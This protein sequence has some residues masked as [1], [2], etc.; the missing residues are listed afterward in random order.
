MVTD[1]KLYDILGVVPNATEGDI[2]KAYTKLSKIWHPDKHVTSTDAEKEEAHCK[3]QEINNAKEILLDSE[4]RCLYDQIGMDIMNNNGS[5]PEPDMHNPF[6]HMFRSHF[7]FNGR[8]QERNSGP[9]DIVE[10]LKVTLD[11]IYNEETMPFSYMQKHDCSTCN[12]E[13]TK[14]GKSS[15]CAGCNGKGMRVRIIRNGNMIQ[16][17]VSNCNICNSTGRV[18]NNENKC[19]TCCGNKFTMKEKTIQIP[20]KS[21]LTNGHKISLDGKGN[22]MKNIKSNLI[23]N[24][25][26]SPHQI[27][28]RKNNDLFV[29]MELKLYQVLFGFDK[30]FS[31]KSV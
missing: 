13:G 24:I 6:E 7:N 2:K 4:K 9:E 25:C 31:G 23:I 26:E 17:A 20:L 21:H 22:H 27:F 15:M 8:Q 1:T 11:Q 3:F 19:G 18:I 29:D 12:G 5:G 14:D 10:N 16:Q 30:L 28:K